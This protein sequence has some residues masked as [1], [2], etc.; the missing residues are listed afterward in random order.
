MPIEKFTKTTIY[1]MKNFFLICILLSTTFNNYLFAQLTTCSVNA[2]VTTYW[3][4]GQNIQLQGNL[5]GEIVAGTTLW[6]QV[7]GTPVVINNPT[8]LQPTVTAPAAGTYTFKLTAQCSQGIAEQT[9]THIVHPGVIADAGPDITINCYKL[10][11][12]ILQAATPPP[13]GFVLEWKLDLRYGVIENNKLLK[14]SAGI[15]SKLCDLGKRDTSL[16]VQAVYTNPKTGCVYIDNKKVLFSDFAI[17]LKILFT[18][19]PESFDE[20]KAVVGCASPTQKNGTWSFV[21]PVGG[22]GASFT[23]PNAQKTNFK[24]LQSGTLYIIRWSVDTDCG[25]KISVQDTLRTNIGKRVAPFA[26]RE[27]KSTFCAVPDSFLLVPPQAADPSKGETGKWTLIDAVA[28]SDLPKEALDAYG[29][30]QAI[31]PYTFDSTRVPVKGFR[32]GFAYQFDYVIDNGYCPATFTQWV[33]VLGN[34]PSKI[35]IIENQCGQEFPNQCGKVG[36]YCFDKP[37]TTLFIQGSYQKFNYLGRPRML[38][39]PSGITKIEDLGFEDSFNSFSVNRTIPVG[40]YIF[41]MKPGGVDAEECLEPYYYQINLSSL[42]L[43]ANAGTDVYTC[44][45]NAELPG[46]AVKSPNWFLLDKV[47]ASAVTPKLTG[48]STFNL[49]LTGLSPNAEYR[50]IYRSYGGSNCESAYDTVTIRSSNLPPIKPNTGADIMTCGGSKFVLNATPVTLPVGVLGTWVLVSQVPVGK[51]PKIENPNGTTTNISNVVPNTVYTFR[52]LTQNGCGTESDDIVVTTDANDGPNPP[53]AG[54]DYCL[55]LGNSQIV[56]IATAPTPTG[57][58]GKWT[59]LASNPNPTVFDSPNKNGTLVEGLKDG[60]TYNFVYTVTKGACGTLSDTVKITVASP[61]KAK[62]TTSVLDFCNSK[63]PATI[64]LEAEANQGKWTQTGGI[65][66]A[67]FSNADANITNISNLQSGIYKFRYTLKNEACGGSYDEVT[68]KIGGATPIIKLGKDTTLCSTSKGLLKLNAP[69]AAG[70]TGFWV[71]PDITTNQASAGGTFVQNTNTSDPKAILQLNPGKTRIRWYLIPPPPCNTQPSFDDMVVDYVVEASVPYDTLK[72]CNGTIIELKANN[73][74]TGEWSQVSGTNV[75]NLPKNQVGD[76]PVFLKLNGEGTYKFRFTVAST[77]C[78]NSQKDVVVINHIGVAPN[79]GAEDTLCVKDAILLSAN[80]L[81]KGYTA[82]WTVEKAPLNAPPPNFSPNKNAQQVRITNLRNGRYQFLYTISDGICTFSDIV[83]DS[84]RL[85]LIDAG[86]DKVICRD[87]SVQLTPSATNLKWLAS[88]KNPSVTVSNSLTGKITG[89]TKTG[90]YLFFLTDPEGCSDDIKVSKLP[91]NIITAIPKDIT[92]CV[93]D[94]ATLEAT[95][96]APNKPF[97][98]QWQSSKDNGITWSSIANAT[99][100]PFATNS[101]LNNNTFEKYRIIVSDPI[102]GSDTSKAIKVSAISVFDLSPN[103]EAC[104]LND[105]NDNNF[106]DFTKLI[107]KGDPSP[108]WTSLDNVEPAGT[109]NKKDFTGWKPNKTYRFLATTTNAQAPC[110]NVTDTLLVF[111]KACCPKVT[112]VASVNQKITCK[113]RQVEIKAEI[114]PNTTFVWTDSKGKALTP[115]QLTHQVSVIGTYFLEVKDTASGCGYRD[116][117]QVLQNEPFITD[118]IGAAVQPP[119]D[120]GALG[121]YNL[122]EVKGGTAP[123][124]YSLNGKKIPSA[125]P[126]KDLSPGKYTLLV[127]DKNGCTAERIYNIERV[128]DWSVKLYRDTLLDWG[129]GMELEA[130]VSILGNKIKNIQWFGD[131]KLIDSSKLLTK[132]ITPSK[133]TTYEILVFDIK[134]CSRRAK[135]VVQVKF[136]PKI[137]APNA[138]SPNDDGINDRFRLFSNRY[139]KAVNRLDI[140]DRWGEWIYTQGIMSLDDPLFGWDGTF[141][142]QAMNNAIFVWVAEVEYLNGEKAILKGDVML[143]R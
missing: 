120:E 5:A 71:F 16:T 85:N 89:L 28:Y 74:I 9:V 24:N 80:I 60:Q 44:S 109:W 118:L 68:V 51:I 138:F 40:N 65:P 93:G 115:T 75:Q 52:F 88:A 17:P 1:I 22:G 50:Y 96:D 141:R 38:A 13:A 7:A 18:S 34:N 90:D 136:D 121:S 73:V 37:F 84:I 86:L 35:E 25:G 36:K 2:G 140:F 67:I 103:I 15:F 32:K 47:P 62:I 102:C 57:A 112:A 137:Y 106:V 77:V 114:S 49:K 20:I 10:E 128:D 63:L 31:A 41:E 39:A 6:T 8:S 98:I 107:L 64:K 82:T 53:N 131:G 11:P 108:T 113:V 58:T 97:T 129:E 45:S 54:K 19:C 91:N 27:L 127:E 14:P 130:V 61:P 12:I 116:S 56:L 142:N 46:N 76:H 119:C 122:T 139:I 104:N 126:I 117:V 143:M 33:I 69:T 79:I 23:Q 42:P 83:G 29:N 72:I 87:T 55:P 135:V 125:N 132:N 105:G 111:I 123:F 92:I 101:F 100:N 43:K 81:P 21:T 94:K 110:I 134:G 26:P 133:T 3:C 66:G 48:D 30:I 59:T 124:I 70:F 78:G 99:N 4:F 95:I